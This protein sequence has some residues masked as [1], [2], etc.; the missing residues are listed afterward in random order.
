[1]SEEEVVRAVER[2]PGVTKVTTDLGDIPLEH[3]G[4]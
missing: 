1:V 3:D 2:V 4:V